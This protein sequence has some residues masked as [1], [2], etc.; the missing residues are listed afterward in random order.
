[1]QNLALVIVFN[2]EIMMILDSGLLFWSPCRSCGY[3]LD[4]LPRLW[5]CGFI[6]LHSAMI[7]RPVTE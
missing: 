6:V 2:T 3:K 5:L 7:G 1:M 4:V